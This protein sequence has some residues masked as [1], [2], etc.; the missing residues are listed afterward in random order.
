MSDRV[1]GKGNTPGKNED[2]V[3]IESVDDKSVSS[4]SHIEAFYYRRNVRD[5]RKCPNWC[6]LTKGQKIFLGIIIAITLLCALIGAF[7]PIEYFG[8]VPIPF[9]FLYMR[10]RIDGGNA[11]METAQNATA[12]Q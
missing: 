3:L 4:I 1:E 7:I 8:T 10:V 2:S 12:G 9:R 11:T 6:S 5:R